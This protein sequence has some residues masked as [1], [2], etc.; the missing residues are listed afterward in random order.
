MLLLITDLPVG[1][2]IAWLSLTALKWG[3][4]QCSMTK[5]EKLVTPWLEYRAQWDQM[6]EGAELVTSWPDKEVGAFAQHPSNDLPIHHL[7][8]RSSSSDTSSRSSTSSRP[9]SPSTW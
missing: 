3:S 2:N 4:I 8:F 5:V 7:P 9:A 6:L 1:R